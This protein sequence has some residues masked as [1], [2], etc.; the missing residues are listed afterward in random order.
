MPNI[1]KFKIAKLPKSKLSFRTAMKAP[2]RSHGK[3]LPTLK[4]MRVPKGG[5]LSPTLRK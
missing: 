5:L 4:S 1:A 3:R 2:R